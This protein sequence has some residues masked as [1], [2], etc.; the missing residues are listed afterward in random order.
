MLLSM[1]LSLVVALG[2]AA[3][4][5]QPV[6]P[7]KGRVTDLTGTLTADQ[8]SSLNK[9]LSSY[10]ERKGIQLAILMVQ[11]TRPEAIEQ[12]AMRVVEQW[13]LGRRKIDDGALLLVAKNDR[14]VRL[15]VGY[16]LEGALDDVKARRVIAEII[17]PYFRQG[18]FYGGVTAG[19]EQIQRILDGE[20]LPTPSRSADREGDI[21]QAWPAVLVVTLVLGGILRRV[22]GRLPGAL[23]AGGVL[24]ALA[25]LA[26]GTLTA[27]LVAGLAGFFVTLLGIG[28]GG[29]HGRGGWPGGGGIGGG[30]FRGGGGG[31]G[32]GGASG[33]W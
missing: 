29:H 16:G 32:G 31:F 13:K 27:V 19:M 18:D 1:A 12:Y 17:T 22:L 28:L 10:E 14:E 11:T 8:V 3:Q 30:G 4:E 5:L 7:L 33:R 6:P 26:V 15:E 21:R 25:W 2:A 24:S 9:S 20:A 23:V